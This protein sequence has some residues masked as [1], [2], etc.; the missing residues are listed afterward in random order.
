MDQKNSLIY[1]IP[2]KVYEEVEK[3]CKLNQIENINDFMFQCFKQGFDIKK[4]GL[5]GDDSG[6]TGVIQEKIVEVEVIREKRV[7]VP[8]EVIKEVIVEKEIPIEIITEKVVEKIVEVP[9]EKIVV[10]TEY[11]TDD[12][13]VTELLDM[14]KSLESEIENKN[15]QLIEIT[16]QLEEKSNQPVKTDKSHLLQETIQ[17]LKKQNIDLENQVKE[18][19]EKLKQ[20]DTFDN[21]K[22]VVYHNGSDINKDLI[23]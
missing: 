17:K 19:K 8:I 22:K 6:K 13:K 16:K 7:E 1:D 18:L 5:L 21:Q 15:Q 2:K 12:S 23:K 3:Y 14:I 10:K 20:V 4:Y 11:I 9:V